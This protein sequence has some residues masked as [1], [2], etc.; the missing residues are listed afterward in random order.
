[1]IIII[2]IISAWM[3]LLLCGYSATTYA[4]HIE[5]FITSCC[6]YRGRYDFLGYYYYNVATRI[7]QLLLYREG[8]LVTIEGVIR[9]LVAPV[10]LKS[11]RNDIPLW[12]LGMSFI[13]PIPLL[14]VI[15]TC[16][17]IW[18]QTPLRLALKMRCLW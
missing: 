3:L 14:S 11:S 9:Y 17:N 16:L 7:P 5:G 1:M 2:S 4:L 12:S 13:E 6:V 8:S 15:F 10:I 18:A